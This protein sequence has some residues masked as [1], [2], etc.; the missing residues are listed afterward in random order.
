LVGGQARKETPVRI[1]HAVSTCCTYPGLRKG[2]NGDHDGLNAFSG[3]CLVAVT[4]FSPGPGNREPGS[5]TMTHV[6]PCAH[7]ARMLR[8]HRWLAKKPGERRKTQMPQ[9][10]ICASVSRVAAPGSSATAV[11]PYA[12]NESRSAP[13]K[14][15]NDDSAERCNQTSLAF[16]S[17]T[18][19]SLSVETVSR[20]CAC[21]RQA[22]SISTLQVCN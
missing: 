1:H 15:A 22:W 7:A 5:T 21:A 18:S 4:I 2:R 12:A 17:A 20:P 6:L 13:E 14:S 3:N 11:T 19:E 16:A 8:T 10:A 9:L